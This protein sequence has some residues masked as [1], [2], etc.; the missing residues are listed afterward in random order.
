MGGFLLIKIFL[1]LL[2]FKTLTSLT[3]SYNIIIIYYFLMEVIMKIMVFAC[4][5]GYSSKVIATSVFDY[6]ES[7]GINVEF[8]FINKKNIHPTAKKM[9]TKLIIAYMGIL[10][11]TTSYFNL[12]RNYDSILLAP[13]Y[14]HIHHEFKRVSKE[15]NMAFPCSMIPFDKYVKSDGEY[16]FNRSLEIMDIKLGYLTI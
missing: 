1:L 3:N 6:A 12:P 16:C 7:L 4:G 8:A 14:R 2:N 5:S 10:Q 15:Q 9:D 11:F 13:Q